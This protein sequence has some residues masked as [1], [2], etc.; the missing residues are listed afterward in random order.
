MGRGEPSRMWQA[1]SPRPS[2]PQACGG[3]GDTQLVQK[4]R[5]AQPPSSPLLGIVR[6]GPL[7]QHPFRLPEPHEGNR[8]CRELVLRD[9]VLGKKFVN[10]WNRPLASVWIALA[11]A[12]FQHCDQGWAD[13]SNRLEITAVA[14]G[15]KPLKW[16]AGKELSLGAFPENILFSMG[17]AMNATAPPMRLQYKLEGYDQEWHDGNANMFIL[18][19]FYDNLDEQVGQQFY[20]VRGQSA[21]W[22]GSPKNSRLTHRE[23]AF[24][25]P[26]GSAKFQVTI[27]SGGPPATVGIYAVENLTV[28]RIPTTTSEP[29]VL[30]RPPSQGPTDQEN[31]NPPGWARAGTRPSMAKILRLDDPPS[32]A[33]AI[34]DVDVFGHAE[35]HTLLDASAPPVQPG[36]KLSMKWDEFYTMGLIATEA[37]YAMLSA[38]NYR[39]RV[40]EVSAW[41]APTGVEATLGVR[42]PLPFWQLT[43]FWAS[44][45]GV[46]TGGT[47]FG[48]RYRAWLRMRAEMFEMQHQRAL[49]QDRLRIAQDIHDDL[50]ARVTQISLI[51][52]VA[53]KKAIPDEAR[54]DFDRISRLCREI[55]SAMYDTV[56]AVNPENDNLDEMVNHACQKAHE[57]CQ[58]AQIRCRVDVCELP[59]QIPLSSQTR[60]NVMMTVKEALHNVIKHSRAT[61]VTVRVVLDSKWLDISIVDNGCGFAS[62]PGSSGNGLVNMQRRM[63]DIAGICQVESRPGE[64]TSIRLRLSINQK[65]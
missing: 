49:E 39:F 1:S 36:D 63:R 44:A 4:L 54:T 11:M 13:P 18:I 50:G 53:Q 25:V 33:F 14:V 10:R 22:N 5:C 40:A 29:V 48:A 24:V 19:R 6:N 47:V 38:G 27:S 62:A 56:W 30:L 32:E 15:G 52:A 26:A 16:E 7:C 51:S 12:S 60:H 17:A 37:H 42:V 3:E 65:D 9:F 46:V 45:V 41:G 61:E 23:E 8:G 43:W 34:D 64:G 58:H 2:P 28:S 20:D 21:G 57:L 59:E 55:V 31:P 35:W